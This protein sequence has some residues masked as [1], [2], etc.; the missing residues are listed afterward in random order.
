MNRGPFPSS[1]G[2]RN[3]T[4]M[5]S[6]SSRRFLHK[7]PK[8]SPYMETNLIASSGNRKLNLVYLANE[9]VQQSRARRKEEFR[10]AFSPVIAEAMQTAYRGTTHDIQSKLKR[11]QDIWRARNVFDPAILNEIDQRFE[12]GPLCF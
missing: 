3:C 2:P 12:G 8:T 9:V 7:L 4:D 10:N 1:I 6:V 5:A 11:V